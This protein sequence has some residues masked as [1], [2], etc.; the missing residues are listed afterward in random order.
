VVTS[1]WNVGDRST[2]ELMLRFYTRLASGAPKADALRGAKLEFLR[3]QRSSHPAY[4]AGF[5]LSGDG[6]SRLPYL[7]SWMWLAAPAA[8]IICA[9]GAV[10]ALRNRVGKA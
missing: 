7:V 5:V 2:A 4:W 3:Y 1:L 8:L 10:L 6:N 9:A